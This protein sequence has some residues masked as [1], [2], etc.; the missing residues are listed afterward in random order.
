MK[1]LSILF[2]AFL[3]IE[4]NTL[5]Q[6]P[7]TMWTKT[8]GG[9]ETD[10][11]YSVQQTTDG[12]Y[13]ITGYTDSF[14]AGN[15]D[16][17]LIKTDENGDTLWTKT[18]GGSESD[19]GYSV[20]QT[21]DGGYI[22]TGGTG[23]FGAG[24]DDVWLIKTNENGDTLWTKTFG[25][26]NLEWGNSVQ[27]TSDGGYI[28]TGGTGT[29]LVGSNEGD[30]WLIKTNENGDTLWT[31]TFGG[32]NR[33]WGNSV[34]QTT[35]GGYIITGGTGFIMPW[36]GNAWL[37]K[38]DENGDTLW[39]KTFGGSDDDW[40][41][42]VQQ[43][44]DGGYIITGSVGVDIWLI[45][46]NE[47]GDTLWTKTFYGTSF[48]E[49]NSVQQTSDGGYIITGG[50]EM[51]SAGGRDV[52]LIKTDEN[53]DTLWTKT[54]GGTYFEEGYSVQQTSDGGY[55]ITGP[56]RSFGA[57]NWDVWLIKTTTDVS[58][59]KQNNEIIISDFSLHQNYPNPFNPATI[60][61]YDIKERAFVELKIYDILGRE[62][63]V[64]MNKEQNAGS[65]DVE[66]NAASLP[67]GIYFYR[68]QAGTFVE[69][70]KMVLMK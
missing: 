20:Q 30:M 39:T 11:G 26:V 60:I 35:D 44:S 19:E 68:L 23:S 24:K 59:I 16:V 65:Y 34:Q 36:I 49:G 66:L 13:I 15:Y 32:V 5:A 55:I 51:F 8:F 33:D 48:E 47:N 42:S 69:T 4:F 40:G 2:V 10:G 56:T 45:K 7:D 50:T 64:L 67:S 62:V 14:G 18:F 17:W 37:I 61:K 22:I 1:N 9:S 52:W 25:G 38:T 6:A 28:I 21:S 29:G 46:T 41:Y 12:G 63:V 53:G 43:T 27:Q 58:N 31:K 3:L 57:G 70:K 54:F